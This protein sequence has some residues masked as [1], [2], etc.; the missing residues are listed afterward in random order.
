MAYSQAIAL[1]MPSVLD[2]KAR[3][4]GWQKWKSAL[5]LSRNS[6]VGSQCVGIFAVEN[7]DDSQAITLLMLA[8]CLEANRKE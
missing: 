3:G 8:R 5:I 2:A 7:S 4:V 6:L 1:R